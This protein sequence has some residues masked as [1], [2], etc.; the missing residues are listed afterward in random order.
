MAHVPIE[1]AAHAEPVER[2]HL[3]AAALGAAGKKFGRSIVIESGQIPR[4]PG[5]RSFASSTGC[6]RSLLSEYQSF[7]SEFI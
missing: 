5:V 1:P 6:I 7:R 2:D 3:A 4:L